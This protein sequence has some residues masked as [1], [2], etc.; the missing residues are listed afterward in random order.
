MDTLKPVAFIILRFFLAGTVTGIKYTSAKQRKDVISIHGCP[1][2]A[3]QVLF[4]KIKHY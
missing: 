3:G 2:K 1:A 4:H